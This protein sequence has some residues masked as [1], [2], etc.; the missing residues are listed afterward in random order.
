MRTY[1]LALALLL[2]LVPPAW[3]AGP[4]PAPPTDGQKAFRF[5]FSSHIFI[6]TNENDARAALRVWLQTLARERGVIVDTEP[7]ILNSAEAIRRAL[8]EKRID[9]VTLPLDEYRAVREDVSPDTLIVSAHEDGFEEEYVLLVHVESGIDD[10]ADLRGR[11]LLFW[12]NAR[13]GLSTA[14]MD[15]T[16]MRAGLA[17]VAEFCRTTQERKLNKVVLPVFFRGADACVATRHGFKTMAE[18]NPQ[19][20]QQLKVIA[21]SEPLVPSAFYFRRDYQGPVREMIERDLNTVTDSPAGQQV[22]TLFQF[23]SLHTK[24]IS[25]LKSAL[26]LLDEHERLSETQRKAAAASTG[27]QS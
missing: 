10:L 16:L 21:V 17:P 4:D 11:S 24:P 18:L 6:D 25:V 14:W 2:F 12:S 1:A 22:Q 20:G 23:G 5:G 8:G 26:D 19:V 9:A 27:G 7:I 3:C 13:G 15:V